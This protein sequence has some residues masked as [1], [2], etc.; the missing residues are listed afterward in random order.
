MHLR[1]LLSVTRWSNNIPQRY[2]S[3][4]AP[5]S[6]GSSPSSP[7]SPLVGRE[8]LHTCFP[9]AR[10][11]QKT[12]IR[13]LLRTLWIPPLED[14][15]NGPC[16]SPGRFLLGLFSHTTVLWGNNRLSE[17]CW[18][19]P[20]GRFVLNCSGYEDLKGVRLRV[21]SVRAPSVLNGPGSGPRSG[22]ASPLCRRNINVASSVFLKYITCISTA[23]PSRTRRP[24]G[25]ML[26]CGSEDRHEAA[27]PAGAP[28]G[29]GLSPV[30]K[31][32]PEGLIWEETRRSN[33][34]S[35]TLP[36]LTCQTVWGKDPTA[37]LHTGLRWTGGTKAKPLSQVL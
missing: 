14:T 36:V 1:T 20:N 16:T 24:A 13:I 23:V 31:H 10:K 26:V 9:A 37:S 34:T 22:W 35:W 28:R 33:E 32:H 21:A 6:G 4:P 2:P 12:G 29:P 3:N 5:G 27:G 25:E 8:I 11:Y 18:R 19:P 17:A 15:Q 30:N 7:P